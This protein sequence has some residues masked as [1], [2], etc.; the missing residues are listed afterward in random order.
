MAPAIRP[1]LRVFSARREKSAMR[2]GFVKRDWPAAAV[3]GESS[4]N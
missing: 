4:A 2:E 3:L 1:S